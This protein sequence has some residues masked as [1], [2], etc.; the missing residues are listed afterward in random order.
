MI[1]Q[2][3]LMMK[4]GPGVVILKMVHDG[5][6]SAKRLYSNFDPENSM[7]TIC[8]KNIGGCFKKSLKTLNF[9][10]KSAANKCLFN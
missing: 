4:R 8:E 6:D 9:E 10:K 1:E 3:F 7:K 5:A 2:Y